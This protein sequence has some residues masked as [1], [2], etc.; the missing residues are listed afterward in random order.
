MQ[1]GLFVH[2]HASQGDRLSRSLLESCS[3]RAGSLLTGNTLL[4]C[5]VFYP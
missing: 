1:R 2:S 3:A 4:G 5:R